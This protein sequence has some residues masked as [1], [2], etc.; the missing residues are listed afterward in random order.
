MAVHF[1]P[2]LG[3]RR[4]RQGFDP[5][6]TTHCIRLYSNV[7]QNILAVFFILFTPEGG[8]GIDLAIYP[9]VSAEWLSGFPESVDTLKI[10]PS[11][12]PLR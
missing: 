3:T 6:A 12:R 2:F 11:N 7:L 10:G 8:L 4:T 5:A 1:P 9:P